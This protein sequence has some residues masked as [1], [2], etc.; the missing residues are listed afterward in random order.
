MRFE[1]HWR[2][3]V[4]WRRQITGHILYQDRSV[5]IKAAQSEQKDDCLEATSRQGLKQALKGPR[6]LVNFDFV[7]DKL[8][9]NC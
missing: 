4:Y 7:N 2:E 3:R 5:F 1:F 8:N 9:K 6:E